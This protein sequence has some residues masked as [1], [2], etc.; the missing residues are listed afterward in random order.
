MLDA[1]DPTM[2]PEAREA[3]AAYLWALTVSGDLDAAR[4]AFDDLPRLE[5]ERWLL[6]AAHIPGI[7]GRVARDV[8]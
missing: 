1:S 4:D 6:R 2:V 5:R 7:L 3:L 8:L